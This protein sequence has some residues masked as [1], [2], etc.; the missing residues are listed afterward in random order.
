MS[1]NKRK[2]VDTFK[3][4]EV[5]L[6]K[7]GTRKRVRPVEGQVSLSPEMNVEFPMHLRD[8]PVGTKFKVDAHETRK[9]DGNGK[10]KGEPYLTVDKGSIERLSDHSGE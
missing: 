10:K 7:D 8:A 2:K 9:H 4:V 1:N 5:E 3:G 6:Y